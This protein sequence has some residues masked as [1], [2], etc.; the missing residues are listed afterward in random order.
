MLMLKF[1]C[2]ILD[3]AQYEDSRAS[4]VQFFCITYISVR[5]AEIPYEHF[6]VAYAQIQPYIYC[7]MEF[8]CTHEFSP[9]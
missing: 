7:S 4:Y 3:Y 9:T 8:G 6:H 2:N 1:Q 5:I